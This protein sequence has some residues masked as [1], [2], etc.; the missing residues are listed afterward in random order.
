MG[1]EGEGDGARE[2]YRKREREKD[3]KTQRE[4]ETKRKETHH[5]YTDP[6]GQRWLRRHEIMGKVRGF[7]PQAGYIRLIMTD[8]PVVQYVVIGIVILLALTE[9]F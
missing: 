1:G 6:R 2:K 4:R 8:Y 3:T 9:P 5:R 7:L